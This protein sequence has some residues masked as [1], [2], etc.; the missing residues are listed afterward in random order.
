[1]V[2]ELT[3]RNNEINIYRHLAAQ[4]ERVPKHPGSEHVPVLIDH[5]TVWGANGEHD[6]LVLPV[7]GPHLWDM[8]DEKLSAVR[9]SIKSLAR[10]VSLGISFLHDHGIVHAS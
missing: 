10:Q 7:V 5:F 4:S 3:G 1:V 8:F 6:V 2:A 9:K